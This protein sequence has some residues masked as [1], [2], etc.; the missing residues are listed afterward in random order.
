MRFLLSVH[1]LNRR[2]E[3]NC[4]VELK[5]VCFANQQFVYTAEKKKQKHMQHTIAKHDLIKTWT[6]WFIVVLVAF[7]FS[8]FLCLCVTLCAAL[9]NVR[10]HGSKVTITVESSR[11]IL[12]NEIN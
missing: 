12:K 1:F 4:A 9:K 7:F 11:G 8:F 10:I 3:W 2:R 5:L 6:C